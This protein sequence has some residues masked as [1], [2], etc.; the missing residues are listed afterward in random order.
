MGTSNRGVCF[1]IIGGLA[2][3]YCTC[4][5]FLGLANP[6]WPCTAGPA[7]SSYWWINFTLWMVPLG[8]L[9][10][11]LGGNSMNCCGVY[12]CRRFSGI[13]FIQLLGEKWPNAE[14]PF[15]NV[16]YKIFLASPYV[17]NC[18]LPGVVSHF[19]PPSNATSQNIPFLRCCEHSGIVPKGPVLTCLHILFI[20]SLSV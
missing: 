13:S 6:L 15:W 3:G 17:W 14:S 18:L 8:W 4:I 7:L 12:T 10:I 16:H 20:W 2:E 11:R 19:S 5:S 9:M 1:A